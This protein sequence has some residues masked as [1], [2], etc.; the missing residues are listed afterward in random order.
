MRI[1]LAINGYG[2]IGRCVLRAIHESEVYRDRLQVVAINELAELDTI[3]HLTKYDST[4]GRFNATVERIVDGL[5]I[6]GDR[7]R[8]L[9]QNTLNGLPWKELGVDIVH[10][11]TGVFQSR[12]SVRAHIQQGAKK[13]LYSHPA[14]GDV[15]AT[16]VY[17]V[18]HHLLKAEHQIISNASCTTNC[19]IPILDILERELR[20]QQGT[21]T[22]IHA[23]MH[24]QPV[25]DAYDKDPRKTR[26]ALSSIIPVST[27]LNR[28][29][30]RI[31]PT[32]TGKFETLAI[33][34]PTVNVS[35][36]D[37][38]IL[39][40]KDTTAKSVNDLLKSAAN[41]QL[42]GILGY[43]EEP[44][45]SRDFNHDSRSSIVDGDQTRV[46]GSR[47]IKILTWFDNEWGFANRMLDTTLAAMSV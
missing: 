17:G 5:V 8:V 15:D 2:R 28:G 12:D 6:N 11:C 32:L 30:E 35:L 24:D 13:V 4:H 20:I 44:L 38:N 33:R 10:E 22:T 1:K 19:V 46:S 23:A 3:A 39:V 42:R 26:S 14:D 45:V 25:I 47:L 40:S 21:C 31:M 18:N 7:V 41:G 36:M 9:H 27:E 16:I 34:V 29:I 43:T 37:L